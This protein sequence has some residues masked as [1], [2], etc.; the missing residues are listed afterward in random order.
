MAFRAF[1]SFEQL[2]AENSNDCKRLPWPGKKSPAN[3]GLFHE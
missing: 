2:L 1:Y 3:A